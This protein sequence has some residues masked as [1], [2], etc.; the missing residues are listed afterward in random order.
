[1]RGG[2]SLEEVSTLDLV[3][4]LGAGE[5]LH[6][7]GVLVG[8]HDG[9]HAGQ[10]GVKAGVRGQASDITGDSLHALLR[11]NDSLQRVEF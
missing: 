2:E 11:L 1:M 5:L 7:S 9:G 8:H 6:V 10:G 3:A 4:V